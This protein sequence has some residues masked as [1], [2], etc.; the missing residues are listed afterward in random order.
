M[1]AL[2]GNSGVRSHVEMGFFQKSHE[3]QFTM[4]RVFPVLP[5]EDRLYHAQC[6]AHSLRKAT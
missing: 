4:S 5:S 6:C 1:D 2:S 3:V